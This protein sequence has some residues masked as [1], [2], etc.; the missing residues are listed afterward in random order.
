M[1]Q[2]VASGV[3]CPAIEPWQYP[4]KEPGV[5]AFVVSENGVSHE[6][7]KLQQ[8]RVAGLAEVGNVDD[9]AKITVIRPRGPEVGN[10]SSILALGLVGAVNDKQGLLRIAVSVES[11]EECVDSLGEVFKRVPEC[12]LRAMDCGDVDRSGE[13]DRTRIP[14]LCND[15]VHGIKH[16]LPFSRGNAAESSTSTID[17]GSVELEGNRYV[18]EEPGLDGIETIAQPTYLTLVNG[19]PADDEVVLIVSERAWIARLIQVD[20]IHGEERNL[21]ESKRQP[22]VISYSGSK[23][24]PSQVALSP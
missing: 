13:E 5:V 19:D 15:L 21:T 16:E 7:R 9:V 6:V 14:T 1:L 11:D 17:I 22:G 10:K 3:P 12:L 20:N 4:V 24:R 2:T 23:G 8:S 18:G